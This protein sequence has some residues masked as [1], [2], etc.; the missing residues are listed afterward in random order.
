MSLDYENFRGRELVAERLEPRVG[1]WREATSQAL[2]HMRLHFA[3]YEADESEFEFGPKTAVRI[4]DGAMFRYAPDETPWIS[5]STAGV[6]AWVRRSDDSIVVLDGARD[7]SVKGQ[8][9]YSLPA[10]RELSG[11]EISELST[12]TDSE[13]LR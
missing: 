3:Q 10:A 4:S 5:P 6:D 7:R 9:M 11:A 8:F 13:W 2:E 1:V 12:P